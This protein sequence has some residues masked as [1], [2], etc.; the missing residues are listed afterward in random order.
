[1]NHF[2]TGDIWWGVMR[3]MVIFAPSSNGNVNRYV[4]YMTQKHAEQENMTGCIEKA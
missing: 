1:M 3:M 4:R 2:K